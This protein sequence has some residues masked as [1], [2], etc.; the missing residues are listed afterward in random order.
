M[1]LLSVLSEQFYFSMLFSMFSDDKLPLQSLVFVFIGG[2]MGCLWFLG[3]QL[4]FSRM[5]EAPRP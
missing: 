4:R 1:L 2:T 5:L 3:P